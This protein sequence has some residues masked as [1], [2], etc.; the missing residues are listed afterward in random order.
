M[1]GENQVENAQTQK[2]KGEGG[3]KNNWTGG[4]KIGQPDQPGCSAQQPI[5]PELQFWMCREKA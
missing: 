1:A 2:G 5:Q 4:K 3:H